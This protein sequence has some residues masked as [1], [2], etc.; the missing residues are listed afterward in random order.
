MRGCIVLVISL[1]LLPSEKY[2]ESP[3]REDY[4]RPV[5]SNILDASAGLFAD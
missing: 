2:A 3:R 4:E 5:L 1:G